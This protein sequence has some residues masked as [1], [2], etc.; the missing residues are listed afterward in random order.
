MPHQLCT[1]LA[2]LLERELAS[3]RRELEAYPDE[4]LIWRVPA[5]APNSAGTLA[6]HLAG[7]IQHFVGAI[8]GATGYVRD[9]DAEFATRDLPRDSLLDHIAAAEEVVRAVLPTVADASLR[10]PYPQAMRGVTLSQ[11]QML[12]H[13]AA[14]LAYHVG[15]VDYHR[16]LVTGDA[17]GIDAVSPV[18]LAEPDRSDG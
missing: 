3:L 10:E 13:V 1:D 4:E 7:N 11:Q 9:R 12:L 2:R 16:R 15:H 6:L 5:G 17:T 8:L 18:R 14:H